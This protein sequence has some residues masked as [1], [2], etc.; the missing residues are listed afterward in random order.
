MTL[1]TVS[2][3][4]L[5]I[6][7]KPTQVSCQASIIGVELFGKASY[8]E[9]KFYGRKT[10]SGEILKKN[11]LTCAHP[12]LPFGTMIEVTNLANNKWCIVRVND[13]GPFAKGRILDLS[14]VAA[15]QLDMFRHGIAKVKLTVVGEN[16]TIYIERPDSMIKSAADLIVN[17]PEEE[18]IVIPLK[19]KPKTVRTKPSKSLKK[20]RASRRTNNPATSSSNSKKPAVKKGTKQKVPIKKA[21]VKKT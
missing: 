8:Y 5:F 15:K 12:T 20:K 10:A 9:N 14:Y 11:V 19:P 3:L 7:F 17:E 4:C 21:T 6:L 13:R 1:K 16:D 2:F 18:E